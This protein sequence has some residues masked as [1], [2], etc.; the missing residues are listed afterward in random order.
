MARWETIRQEILER[1]DHQCQYCGSEKEGLHV[2]HID[3]N[4]GGA[5]DHFNNLI[6]LC[7]SCH[8]RFEGYEEYRQRKKLRRDGLV[9]GHIHCPEDSDIWNTA[10]P[11]A[12][13]ELADRVEALETA[14]EELRAEI[15]ELRQSDE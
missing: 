3:G 7:A 15:E 10:Q 14:V 1:D 6:T 11:E 4:S 2:H 5:S 8:R 12:R 9:D 13:R